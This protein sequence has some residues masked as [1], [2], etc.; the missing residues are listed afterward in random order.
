MLASEKSIAAAIG[1]RASGASLFWEDDHGRFSAWF[2]CRFGISTAPRAAVVYA[3]RNILSLEAACH[4]ARINSDAAASDAAFPNKPW[5]IPAVDLLLDGGAVGAAGPYSFIAAF[6][7]WIPQTD[8]VAAFWEGLCGVAAP[9][10]VVIVG[11]TSGA[12]DAFDRKKPAG[13]SRLGGV[14]RKGYRALA[15]ESASPHPEGR[16]VS[17]P[18]LCYALDK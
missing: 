10:A 14:K 11:L 17:P 4:N 6:P 18:S 15:Y 16:I 5:G 12:A 7:D 1:D 13:F 2:D 9:G 8:R 3:G